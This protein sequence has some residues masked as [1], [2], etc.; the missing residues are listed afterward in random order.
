[1]VDSQSWLLH[2]GRAEHLFSSKKIYSKFYGEYD[3]DDTLGEGCECRACEGIVD[4]PSQFLPI[5][6]FIWGGERHIGSITLNDQFYL[7]CRPVVRGYALNERNW[8]M[9]DINW[10]LFTRIFTNPHS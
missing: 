4:K 9:H 1:M 6:D 7:L 5:R 3:Y 8:G 2:S 10:F